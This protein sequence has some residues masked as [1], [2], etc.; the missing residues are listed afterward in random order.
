MMNLETRHKAPVCIT[1]RK[2]G[3]PVCF[4]D[5]GCSWQCGPGWCYHTQGLTWSQALSF[6]FS[7]GILNFMRIMWSVMAF[8]RNIEIRA[9]IKNI[10][11]ILIGL[12]FYFL[13]ISVI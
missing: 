8:V 10:M 1:P 2:G 13:N 4:F 3:C 6:L 12:T 11:A 7:T 5:M 9:V